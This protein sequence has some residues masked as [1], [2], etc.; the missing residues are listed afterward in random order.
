MNEV[1]TLSNHAQQIQSHHDAAHAAADSAI[2]HAKEAGRLLLEVKASLPHG[3]FTPWIEANLSVGARQA[4][5]YMQAAQGRELVRK[6]KSDIVSFLTCS[7]S[8]GQSQT[9]T[10]AELFAPEWIPMKG[11]SY[12]IN[13]GDAHTYWVI[14]SKEHL[15]FFHISHIYMGPDDS[16]EKSYYD[17]T[18]RPVVGVAV[19]GALKDFGLDS[20]ADADWEVAKGGEAS[21]PFGEPE[22]LVD[23]Y[24]KE[25]MVIDS[26]IGGKSSTQ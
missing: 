26:P 19:E 8:S 11:Y 25:K 7:D 17:G 15:G 5:R 4:Q 3:E 2:A 9:K 18:R 23:F 24:K 13:K 10:L 20:P 12:V 16:E 6:S 21:R 22:S 1:T 14:P